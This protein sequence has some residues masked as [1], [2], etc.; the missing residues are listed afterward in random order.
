[1]PV[2]IGV[3]WVALILSVILSKIFGTDLWGG[4][5]MLLGIISLMIWAAILYGIYRFIMYIREPVARWYYFTFHPHPAEPAIR[6]ALSD[7]TMLN[8]NQLQT[9]LGEPPAGNAI[10]RA[11]RAEQAQSLIAEMEAMTKRRLRELEAHA[12]EQ[13][14]QAAAQQLQAALAQS[15]IALEQAKA[16]LHA[17]QG[18]GR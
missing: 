15:A 10:L 4:F 1:M 6:S 18:V 8:G 13:Y 12:K 9:V 5:T 3:F 2:L 11:V 7:G 14:E 16:M 17:R